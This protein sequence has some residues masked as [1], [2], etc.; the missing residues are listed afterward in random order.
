MNMVCYPGDAALSFRSDEPNEVVGVA[1]GHG[2][3]YSGQWGSADRAVQVREHG[4]A[5]R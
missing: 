3:G 2:S 4:P 5:S 1:D